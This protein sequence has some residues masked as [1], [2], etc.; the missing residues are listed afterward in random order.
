MLTNTQNKYEMRR[1]FFLTFAVI[2]FTGCNNKKTSMKIEY[3]GEDISENACIIRDKDSKK[4]HLHITDG[5]D[6]TLFAGNSVENID[7]SNPIAMG[8]DTGMFLLEVPDS[9]RMYFL[10]STSNGKAILAEKHL[11]M[12]GGFNFRDLGGIKTKDGKRIKWGKL[13]R[14]DEL[15]KLTVMDLKYLASIPLISIVDFRSPQEIISAPDENPVSLKKNY[16]LSISPGNLS[17]FGNNLDTK[18]ITPAQVDTMM[19]ELNK[20]LVSDSAS[21]RQYKTFFTLLQDESQIPLLYHCTAGKDRTGMATALILFSLGVD[22]ETV[23]NDYLLSNKYLEA[24]YAPVKA[25]YPSMAPAYEVKKEFIQAG[26][27]KIK[28]E[29]GS[30]ENYLQKVLDVDIQKMR[31]LYLD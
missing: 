28:A 25:K 23:L 22:E 12:E 6:W 10:L 30:I 20:L 11:P 7:I 4:A 14:G 17:A 15:Y 8:K 21:I 29:H 19:M 24:K 1:L 9:V 3:S 2:L 27:Q 18:T 5:A 13:F 26:L 31:E 16:P